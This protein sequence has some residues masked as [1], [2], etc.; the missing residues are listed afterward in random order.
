MNATLP[1][2]KHQRS[3]ISNRIDEYQQTDGLGFFNLLT[4]PELFE[5]VETHLPDHRERLFP[6]TE[7]LSLFLTQVM[8]AAQSCQHIANQAQFPQQGGQLPRLDLFVALLALPAWVV[9]LCSMPLQ[10]KFNGKGSGETG[11]LLRIKQH[12]TTSNNIKQHQT[13]SNNIKRQRFAF[14]HGHAGV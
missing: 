11:V 14:W 12:Q 10:V 7:T 2:A 13:T 9:A 1:A 6:P 3:R 5:Q 4:S 8:N